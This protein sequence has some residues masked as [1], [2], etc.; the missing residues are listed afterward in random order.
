MN[1]DYAER[2]LHDAYKKACDYSQCNCSSQTKKLIDFVIDNTHLTYKYI[3]FTAL[4][5]KASDSSINVLCLQKQSSLIGAYDARS[6]CHKVI[7]P[8]EMQTLHK[9]LGG[10]NEPFLNKPARFPELS[11]TNSTM[12]RPAGFRLSDPAKIN[13]LMLLQRRSLALPSP[14]AQRTASITLDLPQ[15]FGPTIPTMDEGTSMTV[16]S[17]KDLKPLIRIW[18]RRTNQSYFPNSKGL[19]VRKKTASCPD[20]IFMTQ[21]LSP[22]GY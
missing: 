14:K 8:F 3:L 13:S 9:A 5:A 19:I 7:V 10:S 16:R 1:L 12:A 4:L 20:A 11:K 2:K 6:L 18:R 21:L 22:C 15:P 17:A